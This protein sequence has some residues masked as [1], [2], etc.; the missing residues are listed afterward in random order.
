L[1]LLSSR[2][3]LLM[4]MPAK[5]GGIALLKQEGVLFLEFFW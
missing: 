1:L 5:V 4:N 3:L 2:R